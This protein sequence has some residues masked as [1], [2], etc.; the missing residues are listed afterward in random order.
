MEKKVELK[1]IIKREGVHYGEKSRIKR[2]YK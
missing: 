1:E 2:N